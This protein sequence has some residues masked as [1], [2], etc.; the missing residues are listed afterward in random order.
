MPGTLSPS[1]ALA[2]GG[3]TP[4]NIINPHVT[5]PAATS[6]TLTPAALTMT[7]C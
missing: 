5:V 6:T 4:A 3:P 1:C 7:K 2:V